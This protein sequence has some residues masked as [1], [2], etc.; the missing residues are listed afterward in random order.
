MS[1]TLNFFPEI[2]SLVAS[3]NKNVKKRNYFSFKKIDP[4][5]LIGVL[6]DSFYLGSGFISNQLK[7]GSYL[8]IYTQRTIQNG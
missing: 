3:I 5:S 8:A 6:T 2:V 1:K 7:K 4:T